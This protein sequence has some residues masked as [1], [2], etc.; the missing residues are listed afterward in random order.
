MEQVEQTRDWNKLRPEQAMKHTVEQGLGLQ[1]E[2]SNTESVSRRAERRGLICVACTQLV[3]FVFSAGRSV[4]WRGLIFTQLRGTWQNFRGS[5]FSRHR[6]AVKQ[7]DKLKAPG[8]LQV[9]DR[10]EAAK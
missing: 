6:T 10:S 9:E 5:Q 7:L 1:R 8:V 4:L 2:S 3:R